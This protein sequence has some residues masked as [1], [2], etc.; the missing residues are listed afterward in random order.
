MLARKLVPGGSGQAATAGVE[1]ASAAVRAEGRWRTRGRRPTRGPRGEVAWWERCAP[2]GDTARWEAVCRLQERRLAR[3]ISVS[4]LARRTAA[5][6]HPLRRETLSRVLNGQQPTTWHSVEVLAD[7]L[8]VAIRDLQPE[9]GDEP[10]A[11]GA[12]LAG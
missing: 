4:D 5:V 3:G 9:G 8:D 10:V 12:L 7:L 11:P 6:G 2:D 1:E